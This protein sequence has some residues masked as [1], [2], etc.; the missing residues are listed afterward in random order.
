MC[1]IKIGQK[2]QFDLCNSIDTYIVLSTYHKY[3]KF[4]LSTNIFV[5]NK[6]NFFYN[7][8]VMKNNYVSL[9]IK[10]LRKTLFVMIWNFV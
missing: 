5:T 6:N 2:V 10:H 4:N 9:S 8:C 7:N 1:I 3:C